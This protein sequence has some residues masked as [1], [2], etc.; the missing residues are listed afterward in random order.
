MMIALSSSSEGSTVLCCTFFGSGGGLDVSLLSFVQYAAALTSSL[1]CV[2]CPVMVDVPAECSFALNGSMSRTQRQILRWR[3]CLGPVSPLV[4]GA[5][6][7][8][9]ISRVCCLQ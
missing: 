7:K 6:S 1:S 2:W 4:G 9:D 3:P 5:V 8:V